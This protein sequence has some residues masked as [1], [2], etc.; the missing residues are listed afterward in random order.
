MKLCRFAAA[1]SPDIRIGLIASG[2][3]VLDLTEAG[4]HRMKGLIERADLAG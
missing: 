1:T 3:T 2:Q 4:V